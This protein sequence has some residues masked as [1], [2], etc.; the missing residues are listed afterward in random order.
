MLIEVGSDR[1]KELFGFR[2]FLNDQFESRLPPHKLLVQSLADPSKRIDV[3]DEI[4]GDAR[5]EGL[6]QSAGLKD[7]QLGSQYMMHARLA[8]SRL[9]DSLA[10]P[11]NGMLTSMKEGL[12]DVM[13]Q[14]KIPS[15]ASN[16]DIQRFLADAAFAIGMKALG[17][18]GPIGKIGAA[19]AGFARGI[20]QLVR[21]RK[22]MERIDETRRRAL[23]Y[24][25]LPPLQEPD[26]Q[27]DAWYVDA[28]LKTKMETG[29]W[30][31]IFSPRFDSDEWVAVERNGGMALAPGKGIKGIDDF[32]QERRVFE[33]SGGIGFMPGLDQITSVVQVSADPEKL[34]AWD[35]GTWPIRP[36]QVTDVGKFFVNTGRLA[37]VAWSWATEVDASPDLYKL[38][39]AALHE[40]WKR[41]CDSGL[42]FLEDNAA[43]W[44]GNLGKGRVLS[45]DPGYIAGSAIGCAIGVWRC[46]PDGNVY[47]LLT[48]G[49]RGDAI[50]GYGRGRESIG[51]VVDPPTMAAYADGKPCLFTVYDLRIRKVLD[52]ARRRQSYFLW[53]S[54]VAAYVRADFDAFLDPKMRGEL[55]RARKVLLEHPDRKLVELDDVADDEPGLDGS[56]KTWKEQLIASG[57]RKKHPFMYSGTR[58]TGGRQPGTLKTPKTPPPKVPIYEGTLA[59]GDIPALPDGDGADGGSPGSSRRGWDLAAKIAGGFLLGGGAYALARQADNRRR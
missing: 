50:K 16:E 8:V 3:I 54:L 25:K 40:R 59:W 7:L 23:A 42:R 4:I 12:V 13:R 26:T 5:P 56:G 36:E 22:D 27:V 41:Y 20:V 39:I 49:V 30:S 51:C 57:V 55:M 46:Q 35:G 34:R 38:H 1:Y 10:L 2:D 32:G 44:T 53:H 14:I 48:P 11:G 47:S 52:E 28:V 37:A 9:G 29:S 58:T 19:I 43:D 31:A 17:A 18:L 33:P 24:A 45:G 21:Q 6:L 15:R